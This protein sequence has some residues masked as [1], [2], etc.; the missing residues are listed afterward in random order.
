MFQVGDMVE[1]IGTVPALDKNETYFGKI[2]YIQFDGV[3]AVEPA[4][5]SP[6]P[7]GLAGQIMFGHPRQFKP[8]YQA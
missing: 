8:R 6:W 4:P 1:L 2:I 7:D 5:E 3:L